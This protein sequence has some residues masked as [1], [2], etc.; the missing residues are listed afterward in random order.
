M[1]VIV[2]DFVVCE[3]GLWSRFG[4]PKLSGDLF[5]RDDLIKA[6]CYFEW[7]IYLFEWP[8][9][10]AFISRSLISNN[11]FLWPFLLLL[12]FLGS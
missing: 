6:C 4:G 7:G 3:T 1:L 10:L 12:F 2:N 11:S 5:N 9:G 8:L